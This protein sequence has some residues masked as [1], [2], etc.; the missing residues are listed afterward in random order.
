[1]LFLRNEKWVP[2]NAH[3]L[4][5]KAKNKELTRPPPPSE[6]TD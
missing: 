2:K 1:M 6:R 5:T 4:D 3:M